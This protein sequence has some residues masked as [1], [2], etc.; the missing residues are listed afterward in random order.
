MRKFKV[1]FEIHI[2]RNRKAMKEI[3]VEAGNKRL[4]SIRAMAEIGKIEKFSGLFK[5]ILSIEEVI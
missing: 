5:N 3:V 1:M 2:D 4:A